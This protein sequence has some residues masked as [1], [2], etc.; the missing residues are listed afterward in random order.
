MKIYIAGPMSGYED[1][2]FPLFFETERKLEELGYEVINPAHNDGPTLETALQSAGTADNPGHTWAYYMRRDLPHVLEVDALCVL[3]GWKNSKGA[4]LEVHVAKSVGIPIYILRDGKLVPRVT[5][6][7]MA[8]YARSGKDTV[9]AYLVENE[10][11]VRMSFADPIREALLALD[12]MISVGGYSISL[13]QAHKNFGWEGLKEQGS[14]VRQLL[15]RL[16]T[17]VGREMFGEDFW[18][19]AALDKAPDGSKIVFADVRFPNE[20][21][22]IKKLGGKVFRVQR[23][24]VGPANDHISERALD[25]YEFDGVIDNSKSIELLYSTLGGTLGS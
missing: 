10:D 14:D 24:G 21:D 9:A 16:G 15:Q 22:A 1:W 25:D 19:N 4:S 11:Y 5:C 13:R 18:V 23:D 17:E 12:P 6:I 7:G 8:G 2:N 3:P 20:A